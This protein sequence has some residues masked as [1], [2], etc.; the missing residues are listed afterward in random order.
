MM[1]D[2]HWEGQWS[3]AGYA[4]APDGPGWWNLLL[5]G[6][7]SEKNGGGP[8]VQR[9][10]ALVYVWSV[11]PLAIKRDGEYP[12]PGERLLGWRRPSAAHVAYAERAL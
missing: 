7:V 9:T 11:R 4:D 5:E 10:V 1:P 12:R 6:P 3:R 8:G 2:D